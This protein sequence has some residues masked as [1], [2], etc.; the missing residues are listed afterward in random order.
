MTADSEGPEPVGFTR[1]PDGRRVAYRRFGDAA[2]LPVLALHGT[3]G[4]RLK[5]AMAHDAARAAGL[6]LV[7]IDRWGYGMTDTHPRPSLA[8]FATDMTAFADALGLDRFGVLGVS[9]GGPYAVAAASAMGDRVAALALVAPVGPMAGTAAAWDMSPFH[10]AAFR[11]LSQMPGVMRLVFSGFRA[12]IGRNPLL[13]M[14]VASARAALVDRRI[15][16]RPAER[17][18]LVDAF[19]A[20]LQPGALGPAIDMRLFGRVWDIAPE[21]V[22]APSRLWIGGAD[23]H[24]PIAAARLLADRIAGCRRV[25]LDGAGHYWVMGNMPEVLGWLAAAM[26]DGRPA[27]LKR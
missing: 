6:D 8:A 12:L 9:G 25:D 10:V 11:G 23:R 1:L 27:P 18:S 17:Q 13:A 14:R 4:S 7:S 15:V 26:T 21:R 16:C 2:G 5:Y 22:S 3:P 20:G 24:V 19:R